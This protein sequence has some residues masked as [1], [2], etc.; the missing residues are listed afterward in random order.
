LNHSVLHLGNLSGFRT[1]ASEKGGAQMKA[2]SS[3]QEGVREEPEQREGI[4][5]IEQNSITLVGDDSDQQFDIHCNPARAEWSPTIGVA[6]SQAD[7]LQLSTDASHSRR[8][9]F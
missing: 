2:N 8:A 9:A 5:R 7:G 3:N 4:Q 1:R 6:I